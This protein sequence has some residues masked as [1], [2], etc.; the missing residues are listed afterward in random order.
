MSVTVGGP[1]TQIEAEALKKLISEREIKK[2]LDSNPNRI[3][4]QKTKVQLQELLGFYERIM[5]SIDATIRKFANNK[6]ITLKQKRDMYLIQQEKELAQAKREKSKFR[7]YL[8]KI[9]TELDELK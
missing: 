6:Q 9:N 2:I 5:K 8:Q 3:E 7:R 1:A 4:L